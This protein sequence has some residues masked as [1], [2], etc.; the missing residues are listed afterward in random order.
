LGHIYFVIFKYLQ[1]N[2]LRKVWRK[3]KT[4]INNTVHEK[5]WSTIQFMKNN[6]P[7]YSSWKTMI[8]NTV[9]EKQW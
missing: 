1:E 3:E 7:Q 9:H 6:D 5:Q 4:M 2:E 8:H